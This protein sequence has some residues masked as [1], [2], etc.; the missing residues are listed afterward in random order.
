[1]ALS[2]QLM[3]ADRWFGLP[4]DVFLDF[5]HR[6]Q[7]H[8]STSCSFEQTVTPCCGPTS[9]LNSPVSSLSQRHCGGGGSLPAC[10]R[11]PIS[12]PPYNDHTHFASPIALMQCSWAPGSLFV[13]DSLCLQPQLVKTCPE[14][15]TLG[16]DCCLMGKRGNYQIMSSGWTMLPNATVQKQPRW[17]GPP[18]TCMGVYVCV[19]PVM[20]RLPVL[21]FTQWLLGDTPTPASTLIR[22]MGPHRSSWNYGCIFIISVFQSD[23]HRLVNYTEI[24]YVLVALCLIIIYICRFEN[25]II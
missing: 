23:N 20:G 15:K 17:V 12:S 21:P 7:L 10:C 9:A 5:S 8:L 24:L 2:I 18:P 3:V 22:R 14:C 19:C 6:A 13:C 1:M 4:L 25:L 11:R 16:L